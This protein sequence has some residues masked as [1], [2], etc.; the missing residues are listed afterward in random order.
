MAKRTTVNLPDDLHHA[1]R[2][3]AAKRRTT[4]SGLLVEGLE[5]ILK[6]ADAMPAAE[7]VKAWIS[8]HYD[9]GSVTV[10]AFPGLPGGHRVIDSKG[11]EMLVF[12]DFMSDTVRHTEQ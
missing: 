11:D 12:Y 9:E 5:H 1:A 2:I 7:K 4:L 10:E 3:Y 8:E 6:E